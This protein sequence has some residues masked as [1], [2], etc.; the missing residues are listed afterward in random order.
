MSK[1]LCNKCNNYFTNKSGNF[2][3]HFLVCDG[4]YTSSINRGICKHCNIKFDLSDKPKGWMANHSRW[5]DLNPKKFV[6]NNIK[7]MQTPESRFKASEG[8]KKAWKEGRYE[9]VNHKT[10][11]GKT[12]S[13]NSKKL[14]SESALKSKHRRILKSTRKYI[15]KDGNEILLDSSWEECLA[16]RL[17]YLNIKWE[18]PKIPIQWCDKKGIFHNYFP[19]FYLIDF[20]I[21][22]DPKNDIVYNKT[23]DK[24]EALKN[25]LPN[26]IILRSLEECEKF[27]IKSA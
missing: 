18:R 23:I 11:L 10:F 9:H 25:I 2:K 4:N 15:C 20:N 3:R 24:I 5:C 14:M 16:K 13:E 12:H 6:S 7:F 22:L 8:I 19:D 27:N 21:Y 1:T 17:D 26:L